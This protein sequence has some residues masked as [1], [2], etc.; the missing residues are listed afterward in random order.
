MA[1]RQAE[2]W[3]RKIAIV[4]GTGTVP[5]QYSTGPPVTFYRYR[6]RGVW[7][8]CVFVKLKRVHFVQRFW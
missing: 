7:S 5:V 8:R 6:L 2:V 1:K 4:P 3:K